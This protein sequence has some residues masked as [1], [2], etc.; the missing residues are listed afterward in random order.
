[1][2]SFITRT[3]VSVSAAL[4]PVWVWCVVFACNVVAFVVFGTLP[5]FLGTL[6]TGWLIGY[7]LI[8]RRDVVR[9][10]I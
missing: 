7:S 2:L 9:W 3:V 1:M 5:W 10:R 8:L 4:P 6:V